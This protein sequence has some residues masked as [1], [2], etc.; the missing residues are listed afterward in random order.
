MS[1]I[2]SLRKYF[3]ECPAMDGFTAEY[4]DWTDEKA[5]NYGISPTG[6]TRVKRYIDGTEQRR[7]DFVIYARF[8]TAQGALNM[9]N[10][11]WVE[12]FQ[13]YIRKQSLE[14]N[15]P[16]GDEKT[17]PEKLTASNGLLFSYD[18]SGSSGVYQI[19]LQYTYRRIN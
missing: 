7:Y 1:I 11:E 18:Q 17:I 16:E 3:S 6:D 8:S 14:G 5:D 9:Q 15:L 10:S 19:Q 12:E 4:V 13:E 2:K